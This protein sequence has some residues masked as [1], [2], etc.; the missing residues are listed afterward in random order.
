[1]GYVSSHLS[2]LGLDPPSFRFKFVQFSDHSE[3][4][5]STQT[6]SYRRGLLM[7]LRSL[8]DASI[9]ILFPSGPVTLQQLLPRALRSWRTRLAET[10][11]SLRI[12][13]HSLPL[14]C[15]P[16]ILL[17]CPRLRSFSMTGDNLSAEQEIYNRNTKL[18]HELL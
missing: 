11:T 16:L 14:M 4:S 10:L 17:A 12:R 15:P 8:Y 1:M 3:H 18:N 13:G 6:E 9:P 5:E 2:S 7:F